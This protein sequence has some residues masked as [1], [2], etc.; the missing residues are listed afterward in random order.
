MHTA[1]KNKAT[2]DPFRPE[3][4]EDIEH[5]KALQLEIHETF[6]NLVK[7]RRGEKLSDNPD[8]VHWVCSGQAHE[9]LEL[10]LVDG[11]GDMRSYLQSQYGPKTKLKL[12]SAATR[13]VRTQGPV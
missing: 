5:L 3:N 6:I 11:L 1:G 10:G 13:S 2:L 12:I 7:E 8:L 4:K 9:V